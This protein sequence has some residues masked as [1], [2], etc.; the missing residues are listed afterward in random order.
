MTAPI[1]SDKLSTLLP[2]TGKP[3]VAKPSVP[4]ERPAKTELEPTAVQNPESDLG[5]TNRLLADPAPARA[6]VL[7]THAE[8]KRALENLEET[9]VAQ[10]NVA[11]A[12]Y[13]SLNAKQAQVLLSA[14]NID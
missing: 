10:P 1:T 2:D 4:T 3:S 12:A 13:G 9:L 14:P 11:L 7:S 8:A 5:G 6:N